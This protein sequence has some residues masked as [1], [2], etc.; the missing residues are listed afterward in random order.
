VSLTI[1]EW[2]RGHILT[3]FPWNTYG[4]ALT[5]SLVLAQSAAWLGIWGLTFLTVAIFASPAV[6][7]DDHAVTRRRWMP[8]VCGLA[9]LAALVLSGTVRLSSNPTA[10][11]EGV[12][13]RLVQPNL[14]PDATND[15]A[16]VTRNLSIYRRLSASTTESE[17][18][19]LRDG[20]HLMWPEN[21]LPIYRFGGNDAVARFMNFL[22]QGAILITGGAR[23][24]SIGQGG[25]N[26]GAYNSAFVM[27][28]NGTVLSVYDKVHLVPIGEYLPF[29]AWLE[30]LDLTQYLR[31]SGSLLTGTD[32]HN[33]SAPGTP[34]FRPLICYEAI[35]PDEVIA[36]GERPSWIVNLTNDGWFGNS[37]GPYQ[38]F[39]QARVRAIEQGLPLVRVANTGISAIVDPLGRIIKSLPL[40][41]E[42]IIDGELPRALSPTLYARY[43]DWEVV[44]MV[45]ISLLFL[46]FRRI[47]TERNLR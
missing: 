39:Q 31:S 35:F 41:A 40:D 15:D 5:G 44:L 4:Y 2:T 6:L 38:H 34:D 25:G 7:A 32:R 13:L 10:Y 23:L 21:A 37:A 47:A 26:I 9:V 28:R 43:G 12:R 36:H 30:R 3:G 45:G 18:Q 11:V 8:T 24:V 19:G 27:D 17:P 20:T 33:L 14:Q 1:I 22:P 16:A 29:Q 46:C 42:G